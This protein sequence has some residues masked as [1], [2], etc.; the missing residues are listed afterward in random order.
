M[1]RCG[2]MDILGYTLAALVVVFCFSPASLGCWLAK[3]RLAYREAM[4][5]R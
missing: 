1:I 5:D 4:L 3:V 2:V